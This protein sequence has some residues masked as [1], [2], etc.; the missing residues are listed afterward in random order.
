MQKT[1]VTYKASGVDIDVQD[2][3]L[4]VVKKIAK[5]TFT[6]NVISDIG[7]FGGLFDIGDGKILVASADGV[8]T[9]IKVAKMKGVYD[10]IGHDLVNHCVNDILALGAKPLF[11]LDYFA[12]GKL[13]GNVLIEVAKGLAKGCKENKCALI[14]GETAEM[15]D[16]YKE[17]DLDLAGFIVGVV[18]RKKILPRNVRVGDLLIALPSNG[19]HTNGYSLVRKL[20]F[21]KLKFGVNDTIKELGESVGDSLLKIHR[22]YFSSVYPILDD[23]NLKAIAHITGGGITDNLPRVFKEGICAEVWLN[24]IDVP[25]IFKFIKEKG[26]ISEEEMFRV[27]N[28]GVGLI[29]VVDRNGA[30]EIIK[31]LKRRK[32]SPFVIGELVKGKKKV[33]YI[34]N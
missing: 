20:F 14:G 1:A 34:K 7:L 4:K 5:A 12:M 11:F 2:N 8:G 17:G 6:K 13:E 18:D 27:F 9:K 3:A 21:E 31:K 10:T 19:L 25:P 23:K 28:M 29:L 15:P 16:L 26:N 33:K 32:E 30:D 24:R 22:S